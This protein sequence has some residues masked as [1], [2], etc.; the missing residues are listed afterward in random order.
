MIFLFIQRGAGTENW[1]NRGKNSGNFHIARET[2]NEFI[3][4]FMIYATNAISKGLNRHHAKL[5]QLFQQSSFS[6]DY[7]G[8]ILI[9]NELILNA[10][11]A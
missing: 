1:V 7:V 9:D 2:R 5:K 11:R 4:N 10:C 6:R 8:V 3:A